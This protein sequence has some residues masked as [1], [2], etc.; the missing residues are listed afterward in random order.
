M[1]DE[2]E[3]VETPRTEDIPENTEVKRPRYKQ[4]KFLIPSIIGAMLL[5]TGIS[6]FNYAAC[7]ESTD[8]AYIEGHNVQ[9]S[10]KVSGNVIK[11]SIDDNQ[12]V[13]QGQ[14]LAEIDPTDYQVK[15]DQA[16]AKLQAAIEKQKS[17]GVNVDY[18]SITSSA[19]QEQANSGVGIAKA[20]LQIADKQISIAQA[21]LEQINKDIDSVN[22]DM[23][24]AKIEYDRYDKL[25]K[26]GVVSKQDFD[27]VSNTYKTTKAKLESNLQKKAGAQSNLQS[28]Y[29]NKEASIKSFEQAQGK[30]KG[31]S[32]VSQQVTM[33]NL[34]QKIAIAELK[35][36]KTDLQQAKLNLSYTKIIAP[37]SGYITS[38]T[39]EPGAYVQVGQPLFSIVPEQRWVIA[40]FKETQLTNMKV[41]QKVDI[42]VDAYPFITFKGKLD[43][44][45]SSTGSK[46]SLFPPENAVGSFI[47][48]VQR[49][50]V[51]ITFTDKL[52]SKYAIVPGMS[53]IPEVKVK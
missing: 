34:Q 22:A 13:K 1:V 11:V 53:V 14:L 52:S 30:F 6:Y 3:I 21:N 26:K 5:I 19:A 47:K 36:L 9:I 7:F 40:N 27:K 32:T 10:P 46:A 50:P 48:V 28:A 43:S 23:D 38:K 31:A 18:T 49:V 4:K 25:Y 45:Q 37:Q 8:D 44:F 2:I 16:L 17:A 12:N 39:L 24:L 15:Y 33:S 29:A 42:K 51:K 35:Q 20:G 41:G